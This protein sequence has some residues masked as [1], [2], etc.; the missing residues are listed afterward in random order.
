M[1]LTS[2]IFN[3]VQ[4]GSI[5]VL[6]KKL[7][8]KSA[9]GSFMVAPAFPDWE[10]GDPKCSRGNSRKLLNPLASIICENM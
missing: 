9:H 10:G 7:C 4:K 8:R 5:S 6:S 2:D 1:N 3:Y